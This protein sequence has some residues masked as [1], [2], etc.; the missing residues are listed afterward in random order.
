LKVKPVQFPRQILAC[1]FLSVK[2]ERQSRPEFSGW[3][4]LL[5]RNITSCNALCQLI[6]VYSSIK[7]YRL[8]LT[9]NQMANPKFQVFNGKDEQ[10]YFRLVASNGE[11]ILGSEGYTTKQ[12]CIGGIMAVKVNSSDPIRFEK[13]VAVDK[14]HY[15]VL[16]AKNGEIIGKSQQYASSSSCDAGIAS[17]M[18][19]AP[20]AMLEG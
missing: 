14:T 10:F 7:L 16:N 17:V 11:Q 20:D 3:F 15:F 4:L 13:K 6:R 1:F 18:D 12:N 9:T 8:S 2:I 5:V 19:V